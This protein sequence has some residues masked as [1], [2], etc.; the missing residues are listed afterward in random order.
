[1]SKQDNRSQLAA[2]AY[3]LGPGHWYQPA[4]RYIAADIDVRE[5]AWLDMGCGPGWLGIHAA[6]G[7]PL[8]DV[9]AVDTSAA[10][11]ER[12]SIHKGGLLNVTVRQMDATA[13]VYPEGTFDV[14]TAIQFAHHW[15]D[16]TPYLNEAWRLLRPGGRFFI[17][18][19]DPEGE[20]PQGWI[21]RKMGWPPEFLL[22]RRWK[23][24]GMDQARWDTLK[25]QVIASEFGEPLDERHG[26]YRRLVCSR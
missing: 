9:I 5:G 4:W 13:V 11:V 19:A 7:N 21:E 12:A 24:F 17:Y 25:Q 3:D 15:Q 14:I 10:M 22:R 6:R 16:A 20:I 8:L 18:E 23:R 2:L 26:F 1:M